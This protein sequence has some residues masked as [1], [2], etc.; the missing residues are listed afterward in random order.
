LRLDQYRR[1]GELRGQ[2]TG[3][4]RSEMVREIRRDLEDVMAVLEGR[5]PIKRES[6]GEGN[7]R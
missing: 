4:A 5:E 1:N 6:L 2:A 7:G 3:A